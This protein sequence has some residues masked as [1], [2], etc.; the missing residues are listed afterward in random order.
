MA[1]LTIALKT[2]SIQLNTR[3]AEDPDQLVAVAA[4]ELFEWAWL[5]A[6]VADWLENADTHTRT[7]F[8]RFFGGYCSPDKTARFLAHIGE[9]IAALLDGDRGQP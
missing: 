4:G 3:G 9:R 6:D 5:I 1:Y 7:D 2:T 8:D